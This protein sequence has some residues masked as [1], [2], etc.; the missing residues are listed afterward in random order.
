ML[1]VIV[2]VVLLALAWTG[3]SQGINQ[4]P[5]PQT[6]GQTF[7]S[8]TQLAYGVFALLSIVTTF[9]GRRWNS[10][11]LAGW[12]T[13]VTLAAGLAPVV[14]GATSKLIGVGSGAASLVVGLGLAWLLRVAARKDVARSP[15]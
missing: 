4:I 9:W 12:I 8:I 10:L 15:G 1:L 14:W 2:V 7:Q 11:M 6:A 3:V 13:S 5:Q